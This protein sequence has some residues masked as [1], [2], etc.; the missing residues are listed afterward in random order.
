ME[1][2]YQQGEAIKKYVL[3]FIGFFFALLEAN[4]STPFDYC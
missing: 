4:K 1:Q 2:A 3:L